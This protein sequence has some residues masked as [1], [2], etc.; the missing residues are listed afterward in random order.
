MVFICR[1]LPGC[2]VAEGLAKCKFEFDHFTQNRYRPL[3]E[4]RKLFRGY[5]FSFSKLVVV[6]RAVRSPTSVPLSS[7][8]QPD[9]ETEF[10]L[11]ERDRR[12]AGLNSRWEHT[13]M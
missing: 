12:P 11:I 1:I 6:Y 3:F 13:F 8:C 2:E 4:P 9:L 10:G 5:L 7:G